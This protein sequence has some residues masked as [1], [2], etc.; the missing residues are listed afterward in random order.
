MKQAYILIISLIAIIAVSACVQQSTTTAA[1]GVS[2][3]SDAEVNELNSGAEE[4][5]TI[6]ND[7]GVQDFDIEVSL[8]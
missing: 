8:T 1:T 7:L 3:I 4:L 6:S 2:P 5:N